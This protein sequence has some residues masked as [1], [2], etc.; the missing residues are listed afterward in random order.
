MKKLC[1]SSMIF[2][3]T[4]SL[5]FS[6]NFLP[7]GT[8]RSPFEKNVER[9]IGTRKISKNHSQYFFLPIVGYGNYTI[10]DSANANLSLFGMDFMYVTKSGFAIWFNNTFFLG[11]GNIFQ[12]NSKW[13]YYSDSS[14]EYSSGFLG[15]WIADLLLGYTQKIG[16]HNICVGAGFQASVGDGLDVMLELGAFAIRVDYSYFFSNKIGL[17][18]SITD[19]LGAGLSGG[20]PPAFMNTFSLKLGPVFKM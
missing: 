18:V 15:G 10:M 5:C 14:Y 9:N 19:G 6:Q 17:T 16:K 8:Y 12:H 13:N 11:E 2:F 1:I 7:K 3:L 20:H 4:L